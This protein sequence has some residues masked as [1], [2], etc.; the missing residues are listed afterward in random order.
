MIY[1]SDGRTPVATIAQGQDITDLK[2]TET[3][4]QQINNRLEMAYDAAG[5]G[6]WD[7]DTIS[8]R[9]EWSP[10]MFEL[11][12]FDPQTT[13]P[14]YEIWEHI[15]HPEDRE[16]AS[17]NINQALE[18]HA[19]LLSEYRVVLPDGQIRWIYALGKG[20]YDR[21]N[22]PV[23]MI[24]I[25][26]DITDRKKVEQMK[27][28]FI[29]LVSHE[30]R[31]P[32][33]V[34]TGSLRTAMSRGLSAEEV[35]ELIQNGIEGADQLS[36]ILE[37]MLELSRYQAGHLKLRSEPV[38]IPGS[39]RNVIK[40]LKDQGASHQ[41]LT[42]FPKD[43]PPVEADPVR[44]ERILYNLM[45]NATKYSP[46]GTLIKVSARIENNLIVT[47][48]TDQGPGITPEDQEKLFELFQQLE[49]SRRPTTGAGLG[50]VVCKRLVEAQGGWIKVTSALGK[51]STFSFALPK[52][53]IPS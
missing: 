7:W 45:E 27:D 50:L 41:F 37:N 32:L 33:T 2:E 8:G 49:T 17:T 13:T 3:K 4:L 31:T 21:N 29:G 23:R 48:V 19:P 47:G 6:A 52:N 25:C 28:E 14:S 51:G 20:I 34:V 22:K 38:S 42:E 15:I 35:R 18:K 5:A 46:A 44:V 11:F 40:K 39:T 9:I 24:G 43:L 16:L 26:T 12:G 53:D 30:L 10:K 36:S 1:A